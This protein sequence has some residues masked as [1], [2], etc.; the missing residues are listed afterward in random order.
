MLTQSDWLDEEKL[1]GAARNV[2]FRSDIFVA[3]AVEL[4]SSNSLTLL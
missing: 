2:L 1:N 4:S 3:A